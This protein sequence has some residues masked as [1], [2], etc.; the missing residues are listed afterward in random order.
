MGS[1]LMLTPGMQ[2]VPPQGMSLRQPAQQHW[3]PAGHSSAGEGPAPDPQAQ[4]PQPTPQHQNSHMH[5]QPMLTDPYGNLDPRSVFTLDDYKKWN[6]N[7]P[8]DRVTQLWNGQTQDFESW[9]ELMLDLCATQWFGWRGIL[10]HLTS[11]TVPLKLETIRATDNLFGLTGPQH[12]V[13][14][15]CLWSQLGRCMEA[16]QRRNRKRLAGEK[17]H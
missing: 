4:H 16:A 6:L 11:I 9:K 15:S 5:P 14:A 7:I 10:E 2:Q 13:L 12:V 17:E 3:G 8:N 1:P